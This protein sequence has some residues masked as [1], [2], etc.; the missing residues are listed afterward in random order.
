MMRGGGRWFDSTSGH[1]CKREKGMGN[2]FNIFAKKEEP[3]NA[4][5]VASETQPQTSVQIEVACG[6]MDCR[7][8]DEDGRCRFRKISLNSAGCCASYEAE[9]DDLTSDE[10]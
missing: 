3:E 4:L 1:Q 10:E 5:V 9:N 2:Y 8:M 6:C 7:F